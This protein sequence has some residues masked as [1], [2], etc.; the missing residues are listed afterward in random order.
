MF[1]RTARIACLAIAAAMAC[2]AA[3]KVT[4]LD[5]RLLSTMLTAD[6]GYGEWGF[7]ALVVADGH[8]ILFD[9]GA[10]PDTVLRNAHDLHIDLSN[11]PDVILSHHHLDHTAGLVTLRREYAKSNPSALARAHVGAGIF[12]SRTDRSGAPE[13]NTMI[14]TKRDYESAGGAFVEYSQ[15]RE[16][17]S[18]VWL[19]GPVPRKYPE[20]NWNPGRLLRLAD[21][22][23]VEDNL[24]EDQSLVIVTDK[25]LVLISGCGHAGVINT[26]EYA[27]ARIAPAPIYAALGGF[28]LYQASDETLAWTASK[29]KDF[30][31]QN[32]LGAHCTG[33]EAV[34]RLRQL[35]GL[36]RRTAAVGAVGGGFNL[37]TGLDPGS[38]AR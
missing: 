3:D 19:T 27:R 35:I 38:I 26:L 6:E 29:L 16:L 7:A 22:K 9:T 17:F 21:G 4:S 25:G 37:A 23:T 34:Y 31:L 36:D 20:K 13:V 14:A 30:G 24:P 2:S 18:G 5:V 11:V 10:H 28:H 8:R 1:S 33:I 32:L 12:Q 15:T